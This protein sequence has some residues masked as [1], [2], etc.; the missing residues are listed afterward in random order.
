[1]LPVR[2]TL[3]SL[4]FLITALSGCSTIPTAPIHGPSAFR[5]QMVVF[6]IDGTLTPHNFHFMEVRPGAARAVSTFERK[7]Y[8][9]IYLSTRLPFYQSGLRSWLQENGFPDAPLHVAQTQADREDPAAYK[10]AVLEKHAKAGWQLRYAYGDSSTDF[11]A[12]ASAGIPQSGVFA[13]LRRY[14]SVCTPG[15]YRACLRDWNDHL[16]HIEREVQEI[17]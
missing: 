7:G 16:P 13:L 15:S 2:T 1:M 3:L 17:Q 11:Q 8:Q 6:D 12:Y 5:N 14:N 10:T 4:V 9:I